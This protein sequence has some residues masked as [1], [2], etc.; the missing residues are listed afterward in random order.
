MMMMMM[1]MMT[2]DYICLLLQVE[3]LR[4]KRGEAGYLC[5]AQRAA[6]T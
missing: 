2:L 3:I 1:M 5:S 6:D 4:A